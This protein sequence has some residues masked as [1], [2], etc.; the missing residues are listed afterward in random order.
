MAKQLKFENFIDINTIR[1][2]IECNYEGVKENKINQIVL[3]EYKLEAIK[4]TEEYIKKLKILHNSIQHNIFHTKCYE[5]L[6]KDFQDEIDELLYSIKHQIVKNLQSKFYE[7]DL[8]FYKYCQLINL[9]KQ[10]TKICSM[11]V[12]DEYTNAEIINKLVC[13]EAT[14]YTHLRKITEKFCNHFF[15]GVEGNLQIKELFLPEIKKAKVKDGNIE[16][17]EDGSIAIRKIFQELFFKII[18]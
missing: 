15:Y 7:I 14:F 6:T 4:L 17:I 9:T 1:E 2:Q 13:T 11:I 16:N 5:T 10:E 12:F 8:A 18:V 3:E